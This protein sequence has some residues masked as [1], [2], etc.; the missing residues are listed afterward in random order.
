[1]RG[2]AGLI[3]L[4]FYVSLTALAQAQGAYPEFEAVYKAKVK[5]FGGEARMS[6]KQESPGAYVF[7][8]SIKP[9]SFVRLFVKGTMNET[10][11]FTLVDGRPRTNHYVLINTIGK[12]PR[13][14]EVQF[15]W[16]RNVV[17]GNYKDK[18]IDMPLPENA[19]DRAML[20]IVLMADLRHGDLR[21]SYAV[22]DKD[23]FMSISVEKLGEETVKI[24]LGTYETVILQH[25]SPDGSAVGKLWC[26]R[27]LGYLPVLMEARDDG[28]KVF[29]AKLVELTGLPAA[30]P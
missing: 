7:E 30:F 23:E 16:E 5:I 27:E 17:S 4:I 20:H 21:E 15:D 22:Y 29:H 24:P 19:V 14:G 9:G 18:V 1:M 2:K 11:Q 28:S 8:Y 10:S 26:A 12:N 6:T 3:F 13:N 25:T